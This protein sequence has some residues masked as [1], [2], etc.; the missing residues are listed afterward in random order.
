MPQLQAISLLDRETTPVSHAF[1]PLDISNGVGTVI[2]SSGVPVGN[3]T[4]TISN[5]KANGKYRCKMVLAVPV[6]QNQVIN[7]ITT[8]LVVRKAIGEVNF[9]FDEQSTT[10]ERKNLVGMLADALG[11]SKTLVNSTVIDLEGIY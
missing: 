10:Q 8:P 3:E 1:T 5:R 9:T 4:L 2:R 7:G 11:V 6:V